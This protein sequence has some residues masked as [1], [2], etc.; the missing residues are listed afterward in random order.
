MPDKDDNTDIKQSNDAL[1]SPNPLTLILWSMAPWPVVWIALEVF[2]SAILAFIFYHGVCLM[3]IF[4]LRKLPKTPTSV[5]I[6]P[7]PWRNLCIGTLF[8]NIAAIIL[9]KSVGQSIFPSEEVVPKLTQ[10]GVTQASFGP[11]ALY[12]TFINPLIE[13]RFWRGTILKHWQAHLPHT[14]AVLLSGAFFAAWHF[15]PTRLFVP[16]LPWLIF[17]LASILSLG[18]GMGYIAQKTGRLTEAIF[19]HAFAADLPMMIILYWLLA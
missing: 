15:L 3:G 12:F 10:M 2:H 6:T 13:E 14:Q 9:Y 11:I 19:L 18:V 5:L 1:P 8:V 7:I 4:A 17:G 16:S